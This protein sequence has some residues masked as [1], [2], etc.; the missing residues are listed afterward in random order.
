MGDGVRGGSY[1]A[2]TLDLFGTLVDF[3]TVFNQTMDTILQDN[4]LEDKVQVF[5]DRWRSFIFQGV[6][7]EFITVQEDFKQSLV[8]V[9]GE[10]GVQ[11]NL[12]LYADGVLDDMFDALR[13][14]SLFP[15]VPAVLEALKRADVPWGIL[16]NI[17]E[18][19]LMAIIR[20]HGLRPTTAVSSE[21]VGSYKPDPAIFRTAIRELGGYEPSLVLHTGDTPSADVV[22]ASAVGMDVYWLNRYVTTYPTSFPRPM[23][24][25]P[26]L[27]SL[28]DLVLRVGGSKQ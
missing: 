3:R 4:A 27:S 6:E 14:A 22:G 7:S 11:G 2:V 24:E 20:H 10:L 1:E 18:D 23:Y 13:T 5:R 15:E 26:D 17:D 21:R 25:F 8:K 9:L 12:R 28:P 19:D 16:S